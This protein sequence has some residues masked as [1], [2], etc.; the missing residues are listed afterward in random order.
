MDKHKYLIK[1]FIGFLFKFYCKLTN[2]LYNK[3]FI[4]MYHRVADNIVPPAL[5][6]SAMFV[7][8]NT[9]ELHI[10]ELKRHFSIIS[11]DD[12]ETNLSNNSKPKCILTL[13]DG[14]ADNYYNA[15]PVLVD[16]N[17][18][19]TIFLTANYIDT[20]KC[21]WFHDIW[22]IAEQCNKRNKVKEFNTY[23]SSE[24]SHPDSAHLLTEDNIAILIDMLKH[25]KPEDLD[26]IISN[27]Y[28]ILNI[29]KSKQPT[30]LDWNQVMEI[31][32]T[33]VTV[34]SHGMNHFILT[35]L[36]LETKK[37]EIQES[38][39]VFSEKE[40]HISKYFC[41]PNG[42]YDNEVIDIVSNAGFK[43]AIT[44]ELGYNTPDTD[45]FS[46]KRIAVHD[47]ISSS[48]YLLWFRIFQS[49]IS[50]KN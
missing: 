44:T 10:A 24:V 7:T 2:A 32:N 23:F 26:T 29:V 6:D 27:A 47:E 16:T 50:N 3:S 38:L 45:K 12:Y 35:N 41:Y 22:Y 28:L 1:S 48:I 31:S 20:N 40:L 43:G 19:A 8:N 21:F 39:E 49:Y 15:L 9:L 17:T 36:L 11:M 34:G 46:L 5:Y 30:I 18:P 42:N 33:I 25:K 13:D 4:L 14:W 37:T